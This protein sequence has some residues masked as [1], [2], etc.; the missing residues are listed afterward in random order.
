[1]AILPIPGASKV[2]SIED[3]VQAINVKLS[4]QEVQKIDRA[5]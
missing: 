2:S 3:S 1:P 4:D 5:T